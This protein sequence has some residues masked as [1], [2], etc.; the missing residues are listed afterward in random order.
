MASAAG[1]WL[2]WDADRKQGGHYPDLG[3]AGHDGETG[4]WAKGKRVA[5]GDGCTG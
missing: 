3:A 2:G 5:D 1:V 4:W